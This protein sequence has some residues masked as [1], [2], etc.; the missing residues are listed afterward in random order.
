MPSSTSGHSDASTVQN[1]S[2]LAPWISH[3]YIVLQFVL[4]V[5]AALLCHA[6]WH[7]LLYLLVVAFIGA[8]QHDLATMVHEAVHYRLSSNP[9]VNDWLGEALTWRS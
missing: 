6:A 8:R 1:L 3:T 2:C 7:P 9:R 4:V 5:S